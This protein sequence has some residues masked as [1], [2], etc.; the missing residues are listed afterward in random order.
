MTGLLHRLAARALGQASAVRSDARLPFGTIAPLSDDEGNESERLPIAKDDRPPVP[1]RFPSSL[2]ADN[3]TFTD[4]HAEAPPLVQTRVPGPARP[5]AP[6]ALPPVKR[7]QPTGQDWGGHYPVRDAES[8]EGPLRGNTVSPHTKLL[9][10]KA[11]PGA[12]NPETATASNRRVD[13]SP[14]DGLDHPSARMRSEPPALL[15]APAIHTAPVGRGADTA[16]PAHPVADSE[17]NEV[18]VHIGRIEITAVHEAAPR[19]HAQVPPA[20]SPMTLGA[21]L[22]KRGRT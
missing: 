9:S 1:N 10:H 15:A 2:T 8:T 16:S 4:A 21:Y 18:H 20:T 19:R 6:V 22:A 11:P 12:V 13:V 5:A 17:P 3:V 7:Q 14:R